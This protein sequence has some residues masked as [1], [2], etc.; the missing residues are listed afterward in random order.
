[1]HLL[2]TWLETR[3]SHSEPT[4]TTLLATPNAQLSSVTA[5]PPVMSGVLFRHES[6]LSAAQEDSQISLSLSGSSQEGGGL[7][8]AT[9][10]AAR[11]L[12]SLA[13]A[14]FASPRTVDDDLLFSHSNVD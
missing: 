10:I 6:I 14:G 1:M 9:G 11:A 4:I 12:T 5:L 8:Q 2:W 13:S 7:C 3:F